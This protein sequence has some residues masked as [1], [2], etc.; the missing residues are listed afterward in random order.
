MSN[1]RHTKE[2]LASAIKESFTWA[3]VCRYLGVKP[4]TGSQTYIKSLCVKFGLDFSH[5]TGKSGF[6][7]GVPA[8]KLT[9]EEYLAK[10]EE[11]KSHVLRKKLIESGIKSKACE[12]CGLTE[13]LGREIPLELD[14]IDSNHF[15]NDLFN[16]QILCPNCHAV[17]TLE[18][19][20]E[21]NA[22]SPKP[23]MLYSKDCPT[24]SGK[25]NLRSSQCRKCSKSKVNFKPRKLKIFEG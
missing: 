22:A 14:H 20:E 16:L 24:C 15:N 19:R 1:R 11:A 7:G 25:M 2:A 5:F 4:A 10:G 18:A 23:P 13:W 21:R 12:R 17:K 6:K 3:E 9:I 8:N